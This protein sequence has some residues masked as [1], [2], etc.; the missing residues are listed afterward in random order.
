MI[1]YCE[2][3][4]PCLIV[5][6]PT[7]GIKIWSGLFSG[8]D[9]LINTLQK[10]ALIAWFQYIGHQT[11][12]WNHQWP[13]V[14]YLY[15]VTIHILWYS[16]TSDSGPSEIETVCSR[17]LYKGHC[18]GSQIFTLPIVLIHLQPPRRRQPLYKGQI[19]QANLHCSQRVPCSEVPLYTER[20]GIKIAHCVCEYSCQ[21]WQW[22]ALDICDKT[23]TNDIIPLIRGDI[24]LICPSL[25]ETSGVRPE[26]SYQS[27][28]HTILS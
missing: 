21:L 26:F 11:K 24:S 4:L 9:H 12:A 10:T 18:L 7:S 27:S 19:K 8:L 2:F 25:V 5:L 20:Y 15:N 22:P 23:T 16:K 13:L 1:N 3:S 28:T 14:Q 6:I 17:P